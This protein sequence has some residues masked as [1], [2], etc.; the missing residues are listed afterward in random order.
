MNEKVELTLNMDKMHL[1]EKDGEMKSV[2]DTAKNAAATKPPLRTEE[3]PESESSGYV[4][5][6]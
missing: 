5:F 4:G 3:N 2:A 1:F 6:D